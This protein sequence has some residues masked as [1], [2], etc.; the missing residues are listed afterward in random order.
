MADYQEMVALLRNA[1]IRAEVYLGSGKFGAQIKY[2]DKRNSPCVIIQGSDEKSRG[3]VLIKDCF[4][5][6]KNSSITDRDEYKAAQEKVQYPV[7]ADKI[8]EAV[9]EV[10]ARHDVRWN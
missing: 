6:A 10:L 1:G 7:S 8:V 3:E 5:G 4:Q 2:A 9:C